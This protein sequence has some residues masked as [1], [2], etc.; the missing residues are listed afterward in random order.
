VSTAPWQDY[1]GEQLVA[2]AYL[3]DENRPPAIV[4]V[5]EWQH[6]EHRGCDYRYILVPEY[7]MPDGMARP[8]IEALMD[9]LSSSREIAARIEAGSMKRLGELPTL[10]LDNMLSEHTA[11]AVRPHQ[12]PSQPPS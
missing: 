1:H 7:E 6:G 8:A 5:T 12:F 2:Y 9:V 11:R 4:L 10:V 3:L